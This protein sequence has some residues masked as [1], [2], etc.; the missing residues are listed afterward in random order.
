[1]YTLIFQMK[2]KLRSRDQLSKT[3]KQVY[4]YIFSFNLTKIGSL[5]YKESLVSDKHV[6]D[7]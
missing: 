1:M 4:W 3:D 2:S 5:C 7:T 6:F